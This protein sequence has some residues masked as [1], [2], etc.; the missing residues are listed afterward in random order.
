M[1]LVLLKNDNNFNYLLSLKIILSNMNRI[2]LPYF[3]QETPLI[4]K[5][6]LY[7]DKEN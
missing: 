1:K 3:L 6:Y 5:F 2:S 7:F 4:F